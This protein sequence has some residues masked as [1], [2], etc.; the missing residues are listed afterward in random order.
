LDK[1]KLKVVDTALAAGAK[2]LQ[3]SDCQKALAKA[4]I[5]VTDLIKAF[6]NLKARPDSA[7]SS[8]G[9]NIFYAEKSTDPQVTQ[10]LQTESGKGAGGFIYGQDVMLRKAFFNAHGG[11][12][13]GPEISRALALI[14]EA[15][16]LTGKSD[17]FFG[18]SPKLNDVVIHACWSKLYGHNDLSLVGN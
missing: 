4:G 5:N 13:I 9:Y 11:K 16:H 1:D 6:G 12:G 14:H 8:K 3:N 18:G 15:V 7:P 2:L 17:A 10:F